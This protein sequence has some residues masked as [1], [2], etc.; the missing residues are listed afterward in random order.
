MLRQIKIVA[1]LAMGALTSACA[2]VT[3]TP[4]RAAPLSSPSKIEAPAQTYHAVSYAVRV[5]YELRVSEA[6]GYFPGVDIVWRGDPMGDRH[7]QVGAMFQEALKRQTDLPKGSQ[8][9]HVEITV[10][11]FHGVTERTYYTIGGWHATTFEVALRDPET[12]QLL[13]PVRTVTDSIK[14]LGGARAVAAERNGLTQKVRVTSFLAYR[15][16]EELTGQNAAEKAREGIATA[17]GQ[18]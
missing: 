11:R 12:M 15:I 2:T 7:Q 8:P 17:V 1:L 13:E 5:P 16:N 10:R 3:D 6:N 4:T 9:A 14:S 18:L